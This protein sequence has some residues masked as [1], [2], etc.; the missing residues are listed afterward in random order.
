MRFAE[1]WKEIREQSKLL[2]AMFK[3][4]RLHL[5]LQT[6]KGRKEVHSFYKIAMDKKKRGRTALPPR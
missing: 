1:V 2:S 4:R 6:V 5:K 3:Q